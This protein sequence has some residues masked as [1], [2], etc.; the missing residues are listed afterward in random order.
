MED[1]AFGR[2]LSVFTSPG[3]TFRSIAEKP[4]WFVPLVVFLVIVVALGVVVHQRTDYA[5]SLEYQ[6]KQQGRE[7]SDERMEEAINITERFAWLG[8][9][10]QVPIVILVVLF[11][12]LLYWAG[13]KLLGG[14]LTYKHAFSV[15]LYSAMPVALMSL[16]ALFILLPQ[17][18]IAPERL[19]TRNFVQSNLAFLAPEDA[20]PVLINLLASFDFF[21]LWALVLAIL[22]YKIVGRVSTA[23][24]AVVAITVFVLGVAI[25]V[26]FAALGSG[27]FG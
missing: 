26:G 23:T 13:L 14:E 6:F 24:A 27:G 12:T 8:V 22:G 11:I 21:G 5:E 17:T 3:A 19:A 20:G 1:S 15:Y 4:T 16:I 2:I 18:V 9:V 10:I 25:R 7:I